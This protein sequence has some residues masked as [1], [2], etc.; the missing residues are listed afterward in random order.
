[1]MTG[2]L[3]E[4]FVLANKAHIPALP[5]RVMGAGYRDDTDEEPHVGYS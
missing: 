4:Q 3:L 1:M 2:Y 5:Q